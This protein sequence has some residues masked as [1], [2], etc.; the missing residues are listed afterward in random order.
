MGSAPTTHARCLYWARLDDGDVLFL[1]QVDDFAVGATHRHLYDSVCYALDGCLLEPMK[2][3]DVLSH[4]NRI[5]IVQGRHHITIHC[6]S[7]IAKVVD[8][9][10]WLN[11]AQSPATRHQLPMDSDNSFYLC[12]RMF[13]PFLFTG[14]C[15]VGQ[16][17]RKSKRCSQ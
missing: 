6:G 13:F 2:R 11:M 12:H 5:N 9:H 10:G 4:Y 14:F 3:Q 16:A 17:P 1:R 8:A 7:Y 15:R